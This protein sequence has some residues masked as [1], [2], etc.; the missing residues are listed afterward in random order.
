MKM[1]IEELIEAYQVYLK[2]QNK[3]DR[4]IETYADNI[5]LFNRY[6]KKREISQL[7]QI[8]RNTI[9][10][11]QTSLCTQNECNDRLLSIKTQA[12][13]LSIVKSFFNFLHRQGYLDI[14]PASHVEL[15]KFPRSLPK[16]ILTRKEIL[17][18]LKIPDAE[19]PLQIRD[20]AIME[21]LYSTGMRSAELRNLKIF[22][23]DFS[24]GLMRVLGKG[25]KERIVPLGDVASWYLREYLQKSR[26][27]YMK[28]DTEYVFLTH[29]GTN[30]KRRTLPEIVQ[31]YSKRAGIKKDINVH[32]FRH[33]FATHMIQKGANL[34]IV[35]E[36]LGHSSIATTQVYTRVEIG[37]LK[38]AHAKTHPRET[39]LI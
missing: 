15:P 9:S 36:I 6:L 31:K 1:K 32:T 24:N 28:N 20:K 22:D 21:L 12:H 23:I 33:T 4:T 34:R 39:D 38:R 2:V 10:E 11:Y 3:T 18:M 14:N 27:K 16:S 5:S 17:K 8:T 13:K 26:P 25:R 19:D 37:D 7:G 35:Q 29:R 30:I